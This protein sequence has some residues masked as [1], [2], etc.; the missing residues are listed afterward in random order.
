MESIV[1]ERILESIKLKEKVLNNEELISAI[2]ALSSCLGDILKQGGKVVLCGNGGSASDA[3]HFASEIVGRFQFDHTPW[4]AIVLNADIATMTAIANDFG[5][6]NVFARQAKAHLNSNDLFI[7]IS[8]SGNS[9]NVVRAVEVAK[10]IGCKTGALLGRTGG[11]IKDKVDYP[12]VIPSDNTARVQECHITIIHSI[13][14]MVEKEVQ[15][16]NE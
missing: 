16:I 8:T 11:K 12:I 14:E 3:L 13:C 6:D 15:Q 9:E 10:E 5:Y 2:N 7:G 1:K 4:P